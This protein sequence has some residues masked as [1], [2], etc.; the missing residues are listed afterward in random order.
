MQGAL[1]LYMHKTNRADR[2]DWISFVLLDL[3]WYALK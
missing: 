3:A 2:Y 1:L